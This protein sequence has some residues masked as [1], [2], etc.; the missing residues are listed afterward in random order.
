[1]TTFL[2]L[3]TATA[4]ATASTHPRWCDPARC[5]VLPDLPLEDGVHLSRAVRLDTALTPFGLFD[6]D[7]W[8][9]QD[10]GRDD[11]HLVVDIP[12][13]PGWA[14]YP[15]KA[16]AVAAGT[17]TD[18][19]GLA[20][21]PPV[22]DAVDYTHP[23]VLTIGVRKGWAD[24]ETDP[25]RIDWPRRQAAA[26]IPFTVVDGRPVN[27]CETTP[28][29]YGRGELGHWGEG[30][31]ADA[32]VTATDTTGQR[33]IVMVERKDDHGWALPGGSVDP[34]EDPAD[35]A[36]RELGEETG[37]DVG[38]AVWHTMPPRYVPDP[39]GT[40]ESWM[41]TVASR[42]DLG[43]MRQDELPAVVGADDARRAAWVR[44]DSFDDLVH[45]VVATYGGQV[46]DAH[47]ELLA[48]VLDGSAR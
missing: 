41:V 34:G 5:T 30:L 11:V 10:A 47:R 36:V 9:H 23:D 35:A 44:A 19:L 18:L 27:P 39:R 26:A 46:F 21:A 8:L 28:I 3:T 14:L 15:V 29:R 20:G 7:V 22:P 4:T 12:Q 2:D 45:D 48:D 42:T 24:P 40:D 16:A 1:M 17:I 32:I 6:V 43:V 13:S 25:T 33:W 37:L 31:A 38:A